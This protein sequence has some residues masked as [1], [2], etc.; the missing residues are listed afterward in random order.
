MA[1]A[2]GSLLNKAKRTRMTGKEDKVIVPTVAGHLNQIKRSGKPGNGCRMCRHIR[3]H[4][5]DKCSVLLLRYKKEP[6]LA[7]IVADPSRQLRS[8]LII[9]FRIG[10]IFPQC[11]L[12]FASGPLI[13]RSQFA[14]HIN[15]QSVHGGYTEAVK[16]ALKAFNGQALRFSFASMLSR[17]K[18]CCFPRKSSRRSSATFR[19]NKVSPE[20]SLKSWFDFVETAKDPTGTKGKI[21]PVTE[22]I[23]TQHSSD[24]YWL[25]LR[26]SVYC[27]AD[28]INFH[29]GGKERILM[30]VGH[31]ASMLFNIY[32]AHIDFETIL[33]RCYVGPFV[34]DTGKGKLWIA[35]DS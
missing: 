14:S 3:G 25:A 23:L 5:D 35:A 6:L 27:V 28:F 31:D 1:S 4:R 13:A 30:G 22:D 7:P 17:L 24:N 12:D 15:R 8:L 2:R 19:K 34:R 26:G 32:H 9:A 16:V 11:F 18:E 29:P 20:I 33:H 10:Q 21:M